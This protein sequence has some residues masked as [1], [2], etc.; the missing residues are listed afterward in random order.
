M[1]ERRREHKSTCSGQC[2]HCHSLDD[3]PHPG[4]LTG[5]RLTLAALAAFLLPVALSIAAAALGAMFPE[6]FSPVWRLGLVLFALAAG[7]AVG[8]L[9]ARRL[10]PDQAREGQ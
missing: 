2:E 10:R 7:A 8:V 6:T 4:G 3:P 5:W 9:A 1:I